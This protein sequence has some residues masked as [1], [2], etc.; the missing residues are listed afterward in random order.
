MCTSHGSMGSTLS[1][2]TMIVLLTSI[3]ALDAVCSG[4][5]MIV[6]RRAARVNRRNLRYAGLA[7]SAFHGVTNVDDALTSAYLRKHFFSI[8]GVQIARSRSKTAKRE[9]KEMVGLPRMR[10]STKRQDITFS[11]M[12]S[13]FYRQPSASSYG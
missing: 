8:I 13:E 1:L 2:M 10:F 12:A 11:F 3:S 6:Q 7:K 9:M 5:F 4:W